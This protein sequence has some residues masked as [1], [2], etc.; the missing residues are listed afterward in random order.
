MK[1]TGI[2]V[3]RVEQELRESFRD[4]DSAN[5][6]WEKL[7][8]I[9]ENQDLKSLSGQDGN[10]ISLVLAQLQESWNHIFHMLNKQE[11]I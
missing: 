4:L 8:E 11:S 6:I 1:A 5:E 10:M 2:I 9:N 7:K 3:S